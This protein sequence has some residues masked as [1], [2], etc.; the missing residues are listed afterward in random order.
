MIEHTDQFLLKRKFTLFQAAFVCQSVYRQ[1]QKAS[2]T[3]LPMMTETAL[4]VILGEGTSSFPEAWV[5]NPT[6]DR[7]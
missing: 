2:V 1:F 3:L 6:S 5:C 4:L 7:E